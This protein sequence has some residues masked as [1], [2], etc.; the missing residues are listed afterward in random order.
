MGNEGPLLTCMV[1]EV[2]GTVDWALLVLPGRL[3]T[4]KV[5][6]SVSCGTKQNGQSVRRRSQIKH[7][8]VQTPRS[9]RTSSEFDVK[10]SKS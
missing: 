6:F 9:D 10:K 1:V 4:V 2:V 3:A 7:N 8:L 5:G